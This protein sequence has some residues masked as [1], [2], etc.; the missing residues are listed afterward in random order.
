MARKEHAWLL[1][2]E[3][4][5]LKQ[6]GARLGISTEVARYHVVMFGRRVSRAARHTR[7]TL[8]GRFFCCHKI[9]E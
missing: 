4:L 3:G 6:V 5:T 8:N 1:R 2:A 7:I 9:P